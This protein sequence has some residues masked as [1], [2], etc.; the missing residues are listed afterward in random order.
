[1]NMHSR[2]GLLAAVALAA[3]FSTAAI[4][5]DPA[6]CGPLKQIAATIPL[7]ARTSNLFTLPVS[8]NGTSF[9]MLLGTGGTS[10]IITTDVGKSLGLRVVRPLGIAQTR[11]LDVVIGGAIRGQNVPFMVADYMINAADGTPAIPDLG[12]VLA[13]DQLDQFD[14]DADF[15]AHTLK[16]M[17]PDHCKGRVIYWQGP[18][19]IVPIHM[20]NGL[21]YIDVTLDGHVFHA[22]VDT[23]ASLSVLYRNQAASYFDLTEK[24]PDVTVDGEIRTT[25]TD[26]AIHRHQVGKMYSHTF[27][28]MDFEGVAVGNPHMEI[29]DSPLP[30]SYEEMILGMDVLSKLHLYFAFKE[31]A[32][33]VSPGTT[34]PDAARLDAAG[35][36]RTGDTQPPSP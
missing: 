2:F 25:S 29:E 15:G 22:R 27:K 35:A 10:S 13:P 33:Y 16:L 19:G 23:A 8:L 20:H 14:M 32:L 31:G 1:M 7:T 18:T 4:A 28:T 24:S 26:G 36:A 34:P 5:A 12:G 3:G 9:N 30:D 21:V 6:P 11:V 17:S